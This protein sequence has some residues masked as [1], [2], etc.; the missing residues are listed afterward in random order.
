MKTI[1]L[2]LALLTF[3]SIDPPAA[4][5]GIV[6]PQVRQFILLQD[7]GALGAAGELGG[8]IAADSSVVVSGRADGRVQLI[9]QRT[10]ATF[11]RLVPPAPLDGVA[12]RFGTSVALSGNVVAVGAPGVSLPAGPGNV[13][14]FDLRNGRLLRQIGGAPGFGTSVALHGD[15]LVVGSPGEDGER[16]AVFVLSVSDPAVQTRLTASDRAASDLFGQSVAVSDYYILV[17]APLD[18]R[19]RGVNA[20]SGYLF[21][22]LSLQQRRK[23]TDDVNTGGVVT[24]QNAQL[25]FS[26]AISGHLLIL[27]A[28]LATVNGDPESGLALI[29]TANQANEVSSVTSPS[30]PSN[31]RFGTSVACGDSLLAI[32]EPATDANTFDSGRVHVFDPSD[33]ENPSHVITLSPRGLSTGDELGTGVA[34]VGNTVIAS[35]DIDAPGREIGSIFSFSPILRP[36]PT[37]SV[38]SARG[39][40]APGAFGTTIAAFTPHLFDVS[41]GN[42]VALYRLGGPGSQRGRLHGLWRNGEEPIAIS[43]TTE[44]T[45]FTPSLIG[46]IINHQLG[47]GRTQFRTSFGRFETGARRAQGIVQQVNG[48]GLVTAAVTGGIIPDLGVPPRIAAFGAQGI[49]DTG[50]AVIQGSLIRGAV[51]N[52]T[53]ASDTFILSNNPVSPLPGAAVAFREGAAI[54]GQIVAP[55]EGVPLGQIVPRVAAG[56]GAY[57]IATQLQGDPA[58]N[59]GLAQVN[60]GTGV[61]DELVRRGDPALSGVSPEVYSTFFG[62]SMDANGNVAF[63]GRIVGGG[64]TRGTD[65]VLAVAVPG[66]G[67]P[68]IFARKGDQAPG[69]PAGVTIAGFLSFQKTR[70][71]GA[72]LYQARLAG[73]GVHRGNDVAVF[74]AAPT[75][76]AVPPGSPIL[77]NHVLI[78]EGDRLPGGDAATIGTILRVAYHEDGDYMILVSL[79]NRAGEASPANNL[80]LLY[81]EA[82]HT[83]PGATDANGFRK[84]FVLQRKG[85]A[86]AQSGVQSLVGLSFFPGTIG[87]GGASGIGVGSVAGGGLPIYEMFF[88]DRQL[89]LYKGGF[90]N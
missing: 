9:S 85:A 87:S 52:V 70:Q 42:T 57:V 44:T 90:N 46:G 24:S 55:F 16:G 38:V 32:G 36:D 15:R 59:Q 31:Q 60:I 72:L 77:P 74:V 5:A 78:R 75:N 63:R 76:I 53:A 62:E 65:E 12:I 67:R 41:S 14:L 71:G 80:A 20:G 25:G 50:V 51:G 18:D 7:N 29:F 17:G 4:R 89:V 22:A 69:L 26:A 81:G 47:G 19:G 6:G 64:V 86:F 8:A 82:R 3:L 10:G 58:R 88:S 43:N 61:V 66:G 79:V 23:L 48:F 34:V 28:P 49:T 45:D 84:P 39:D 40:F 30:V 21:D 11:R 54:G 37:G 27:G 2:C 68:P 13:F 83:E 33:W 56:G 35:T 1:R 73:P